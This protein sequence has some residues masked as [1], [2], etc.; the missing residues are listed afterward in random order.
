MKGVVPFVF[1]KTD[2]EILSKLYADSVVYRIQV[3]CVKHR[4]LIDSDAKAWLDT[5]FDGISKLVGR[6]FTKSDSPSN[7]QAFYSGLSHFLPL[8]DAQVIERPRTEI[9]RKGIK[10]LLNSAIDSFG[11]VPDRL[12]VP[13]LPWDS[14][15]QVSRLNKMLIEETI[16]WKH[17]GKHKTSLILPVL[18]TKYNDYKTGG[19]VRCRWITDR[20]TGEIDA[21]WVSDTSLGDESPT[22]TSRERTES[23]FNFHNT[24]KNNLEGTMTHILAGPYW[25]TN[26]L[27][28]SR[29]LISA[30][31]ISLGSGFNYYIAGGMPKHSVDR[32]ALRPLFRRVQASGLE[33]WLQMASEMTAEFDPKSSRQFTNLKKAIQRKTDCKWQTAEVYREILKDIKSQSPQ[34]RGVA[35]FQMLSE[36]V[37]IAKNLPELKSESTKRLQKPDAIAKELTYHAL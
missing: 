29:Q 19:S 37:V 9:V 22:V 32:Y 15:K 14:T 3:D 24:L 2:A 23:L 16:K 36:A 31:C 7:W 26:L 28:W 4:S 13:Q 20:V 30:P 35:F 8:L 10:S 17:S 18:F 1:T 33:G 6:G 25:M 5:G 21:V 12:S 34:G 11:D 27:L